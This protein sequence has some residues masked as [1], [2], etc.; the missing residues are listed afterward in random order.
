[1]RFLAGTKVLLRVGRVELGFT[2][3]VIETGGRNL[4]VVRLSCLK[5]TAPGQYLH[6]NAPCPAH[7]V[8]GLPEFSLE[9]RELSGTH[10]PI[11][12]VAELHAV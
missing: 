7:G 8:Y 5:S 12:T 2:A 9:E 1:M 6:S 3:I 11:A 4:D 10:R